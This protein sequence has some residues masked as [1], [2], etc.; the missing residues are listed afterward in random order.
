VPD[1]RAYN[2]HEEETYTANPDFS[3]G[4]G[5]L[6][7]L[8]NE[9]VAHFVDWVQSPPAPGMSAVRDTF[10]K[11]A[12][13]PHYFGP[14]YDKRARVGM[15][16]AQWVSMLG[17][18]GF[19]PQ[20]EAS[21][22]FDAILLETPEV[23]DTGEEPTVVMA[24]L[25][26]FERR[27]LLA[28]SFRGFSAGCRRLFRAL[29]Q[30]GGTALRGWRLFM[31]SK[32]GDGRVNMQAF[33]AGCKRLGLGE[34]HAK[35][36]ADFHRVLPNGRSDMPMT[37][38]S[39]RD[40]DVDGE[41][42]ANLVEFGDALQGA[43]GMDTEEAWA[44]LDRHHQRFLTLAEFASGA[45]ALGFQGDTTLLFQGLDASG[46]GRLKREDLDYICVQLKS[47]VPYAKRDAIHS[48][49]TLVE[50]FG[51]EVATSPTRRTGS[52]SRPSWARSAPNSRGGGA[53]NSGQ[54]SFAPPPRG[55][56]PSPPTTVHL[57]E[58]WDKGVYDHSF[59][60]ESHPRS[61]TK[62]YFSNPTVLTG[63]A[64]F[65]HIQESTL[66][67]GVRALSSPKRREKASTQEGRVSREGRSTFMD[68]S[69]DF[70]VGDDASSSSSH[71][72]TA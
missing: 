4:L 43:I 50:Y 18:L 29:L 44:F 30:R 69:D 5:T 67:S 49:E 13:L 56:K 7:P 70:F 54:A 14:Y 62:Y 68:P 65:V 16:R 59:F 33:A 52:T 72:F 12:Y 40:V 66:H 6:V 60:N 25:L 35:L 19:R 31:E 48:G 47:V 24:Q 10:A 20:H 51:R 28:T 8:P 26:A 23:V 55:A 3:G 61:P 42:W 2:K 63:P 45:E 9:A 71:P 64:P 11:E 41:E 46:I 36:W 38:L 1:F 34:H 27:W 21:E 57:R 37:P 17:R 58:P 32:R 22:V 39:F 15:T 53:K